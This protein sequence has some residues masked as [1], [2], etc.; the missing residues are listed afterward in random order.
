WSFPVKEFKVAPGGII[1]IQVDAAIPAGHHIYSLKTYEGE[2]PLP[3]SFEVSPKELAAVDGG[4]EHPKPIVR[5]DKNFNTDVELFEGAVSLK[6][7]VRMSRSAAQGE[8]KIT[9]VIN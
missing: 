1:S 6:V 5:H 4:I 7:P 8:H 2:G 3:T 9:L